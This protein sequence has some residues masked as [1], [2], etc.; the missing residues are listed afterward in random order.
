MTIFAPWSDPD[1]KPRA[2]AR[3]DSA[4]ADAGRARTDDVRQT[5]GSGRCCI[6]AVATDAGVV[7]VKYG[8]RLPPGEEVVLAVLA[9]HWPGRVPGVVAT[10]EGA[11]VMEPLTGRELEPGDP[12]EDWTIAARGLA[13]LEAGEVARAESWLEMGVRDR[14]PAAWRAAFED[15]LESPV[16]HALE[17]GYRRALEGLAPDFIERYESAFRFPATLVHQDSGCCNIQLSDDGPV[18]F[19]WADVVI[20]HPV[21]SCDRLLDQVPEAFREAVIAAFLEP[22]A[23]ERD[24]FQAM[25]RSNVL[26]EVLRYHDELA[27]LAPEDPMHEALSRAVC[28]QL[29]V[30][31]DHETSL[32]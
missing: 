14:R 4:L 32:R 31:I 16:V 29:R 6:Q 13:E 19:D 24:E 30:L 1:W 15:L 11:V 12:V 3:L 17:A 10:F 27:W 8:Y 25:R 28:S 23:L 18:F 21:F 7:W 20:G 22:L 9:Q 26:H 5:R 2:L